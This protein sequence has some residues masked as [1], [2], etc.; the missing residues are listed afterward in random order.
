MSTVLQP[1]RPKTPT[2]VTP[3][4]YEPLLDRG[5]LPDKLLRYGIRLLLRSK[6]REL[7]RGGVDAQ[8]RRFQSHLKA[9]RASPIALHTDVANAQ[10]Y[11]VPAEFFRTV[12]GSRLKYS[13]AWWSDSAST[14]DNAEEAMLK[15]TCCRASLDDGQSILELGCGW[16]SFCLFA[17]ETYPGSHITAVSNSQSQKEFIDSQAAARGL[18]NLDVITAD[19]SRFDTSRRFDRIVSVEMFEHMRNYDELL[20]RIGTWSNPGALLFVHIFVNRVFAYPYETRDSTDW[21]AQH[22]FTGGQMPS[23]DL[24][25][26]FQDDFRIRE[27]WRVNGAHYSRTLEAWLER[28]DSQRHTVLDIFEIAYGEGDARKWLERWRV[29]FMACSELFAYRDG[30]EWFVSHY[31]FERR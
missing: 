28:M 20:R 23:D 6:L 9:L 31:L 13:C 16:G 8:S 26:H 4:W 1:A 30:E 7:K 22:F 17:A 15:L 29:F 27:H 14:L 2:S 11:E 5:L 18:R 19:M 12:L 21:M 10:H 24:L 3:G 25:L